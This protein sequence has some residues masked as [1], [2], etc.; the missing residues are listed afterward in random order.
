MSLREI[1]RRVGLNRKTVT[2]YIREYE[3]QVSSAP[4]EGAAMCLA[5]RPK[6]PPRTAGRSKLTETVCAEIEYWLSENAKRRQTGMRKQCLKRQDIHRALIEKGFSISYSSVCKYIQQRKA[7]KRS[8]PK[9]VFIKQYYDPGEECEFD[10]GEVKLRIAGKQVAFTMAVFALCH[11]EGRWA[12]LFRH[13]D[14]LAF[15]ESYRNFFHDVHGV[16]HTMVY[17]NMKVAVILKPDGKQPTESLL[18][19]EAFY[20]F[21]HRLYN[22]RAG[23]EKGHVER[24]VDFVRG[25][26]FTMRVDFDSIQ[27]AQQWLSRICDNINRESGSIATGDK[28]QA[29]CRD[30][31]CMLHFPGDF[32]CFDLL[33]AAVDKQSTICV[34]NS[35]YS[36]SWTLDINHYINTLMKKPGALKGSVALRQMPEKM[37][38][39]FRV[40]FADNGKDFLRLLKY[41]RERG[42]GYRDILD[43]VRQIRMRGA[44]HINFDQIKVALETRDSATLTFTDSHKTDAFLEIELGS[45]D[46]LAQLDGIMQ[47]NGNGTGTG[48]RCAP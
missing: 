1:S 17:D 43:A 35:H 29:L 32:G 40:H 39:L 42:H 19:M 38:E 5:S 23:W 33:Q 24:S 34:K 2:R 25:R 30:M 18:R 37:Q 45:E 26:A 15:M 3:A 10:W 14:N 6:Y 27:S 28:Q 20:G 22:A 44:R 7:E 36:G 31:E 12:Y 48:R 9:D 46:V 8:K 11:S 21:S 16:P 4:K 41:C 47:G 13:Q